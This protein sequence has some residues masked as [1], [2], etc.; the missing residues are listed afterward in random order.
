MRIYVLTFTFLV[1]W[2][3]LCG[4]PSLLSA[5]QI[6]TAHVAR[7]VMYECSDRAPCRTMIGQ[8]VAP[9]TPVTI[10]SD[11]IRRQ[12][13]PCDAPRQAEH[14]QEASRP[15]EAVWFLRCKNVSYR[16]TLIP[17]MAARVEVVK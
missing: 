6:E 7:K 15:N 8:A 1:S 12:G 16:V 4:F 3:L 17:D 5:S 2:L 11:H 10:I 13:Y 14:D 9:D